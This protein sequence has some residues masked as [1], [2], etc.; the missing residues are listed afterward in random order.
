MAATRSVPSGDHDGVQLQPW[1]IQVRPDPSGEVAKTLVLVAART[2]PDQAREEDPRAVGRPIRAAVLCA[3]LRRV[4]VRVVATA[5]CDVA[6]PAAG[7]SDHDDRT[8]VGCSVFIV[9]RV[10]AEC[11]PLAVRRPRRPI[12]EHS[13][14]AEEPAQPP[15]VGSHDEE[16]A[17]LGERELAPIRRPRRLPR[18]AQ[19]R[20][21]PPQLLPVDSHDVDRPRAL[22][23]EPSAVGGPGRRAVEPVPGELSQS[24]SIRT[25]HRDSPRNAALECNKRNQAV[26]AGRRRSRAW[27]ERQRNAK[28]RQRECGRDRPHRASLRTNAAD[29]QAAR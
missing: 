29:G 23:R 8:A 19:R 15:S 3:R 12:R 28:R 16:R 22:E 6:D 26:P 24:A 11:D 14:P 25:D 9:L 7:A 21:E 1:M 27:G 5:I 4:G 20:R 18:P 17:L 2:E 10:Q 13:P